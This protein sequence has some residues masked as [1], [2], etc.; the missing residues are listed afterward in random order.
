[1]IQQQIFSLCRFYDMALVMPLCIK[2][3]WVYSFMIIIKN[4]VYEKETKLKEV[5]KVRK[6]YL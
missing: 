4:V 5:M 2:I 3:S 1:M 6:C